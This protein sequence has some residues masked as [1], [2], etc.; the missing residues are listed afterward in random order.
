MPYAVDTLNA[1]PHVTRPARTEN[2]MKG[3]RKFKPANSERRE[4]FYCL[5]PEHLIADCHQWKQKGFKTKSVALAQSLP[6]LSPADVESYQPFLLEGM[7]SIFPDAEFKPVVMIRDTGASQSFILEHSLPFSADTYTGCDVLVRGIEMCCANVPL[8]TVHLKSGLVSAAVRLGVRKQLPVEGIDLIIGNESL[9]LAGGEV[10]P[11]P[12]V[13]YTPSVKEQSNLVTLYP[14]AFP[15][16]AVTRAQ[17]QKFKEV[18]DLADSFLVPDITP[19]EYTLT[20]ES[21]ITPDPSSEI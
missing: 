6:K 15:S 1:M 7:V 3:A 17:A 8:H 13:S 2:F 18:V 10:F 14:S 20:T 16:C 11:S 19:C 5:S 12:I 9:Q 21:E 4:C